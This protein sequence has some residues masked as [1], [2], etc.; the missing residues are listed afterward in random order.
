MTESNQELNQALKDSIQQFRTESVERASNNGKNI[1][2]FRARIA[3]QK[4]K[5]RAQYEKKLAGLEKR[6]SDI[7]MKLADHKDEEQTK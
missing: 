5:N 1:A 4:K 7:K 2:E 3:K 6:N